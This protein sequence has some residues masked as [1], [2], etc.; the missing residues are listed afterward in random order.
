M[1]DINTNL[2]DLDAKIR[3]VSAATADIALAITASGGTV[4]SDDGL[5]ELAADVATI[6]PPINTV[7]EA[8]NTSIENSLGNSTSSLITKSITSNGTYNAADDNALGYSSV[9][10]NVPGGGIEFGNTPAAFSLIKNIR[11]LHLVIPNGVTSIDVGAF[12]DCVG[13]ESVEIPDGVST[14]P[15]QCFMR[16]YNLKSVQ[17]P[18]GL[19]TLGQNAFSACRSLKTLTIPATVSFYGMYALN[20]LQSLETLKFEAT[21]PAT[22]SDNTTFDSLPTTC[23]IY[24]PTGSLTAYTSAANYPDPNTYTYVEY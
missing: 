21:S 24:V 8:V 2:T 10:V 20:G 19:Q 22:I 3:R 7:V 17:M 16:C 4:A 12:V 11:N 13:L 1:A 9:N 15:K 23:K 6:V 18:D 5:E 14:I